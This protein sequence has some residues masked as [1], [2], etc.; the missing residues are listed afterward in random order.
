MA[1]NY[2]YTTNIPVATH[3]PAQDQGNMQVNCTSVNQI[4]GTD[5]L[6]FGTATG[7][8][9]DGMHTVVHMQTRLSDP[10]L[11][12][13]T[14]EIYTKEVTFNSVTES[15]LFFESDLG[16]VIQLTGASNTLASSKGYTTLPGGIIIQW[17]NKS[18]LSG[19]QHVFGN[20]NFPV[21]FLANVFQILITP[22]S[23]DQTVTTQSTISVSASPAATLTT[24]AWNYVKASPGTDYVAFSWIA[25]GN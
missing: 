23:I 18:G 12:A 10:P 25:I 2:T 1:T 19:T 21:P 14:G 20:V 3:T 11:V 6:T 24:F 22:I 17:G 9:V 15:A 16:T 4:I 13:G 8:L 7:A 5:H